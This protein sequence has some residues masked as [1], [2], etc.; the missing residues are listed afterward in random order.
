MGISSPDSVRAVLKE[1]G[2]CVIMPTYD[3]AGTLSDVISSVLEYCDDLIVINDGCTDGTPEILKKFGQ[4]IDVLTHPF[5]WGK[6]VALRNGLERAMERGFSH[7]IS[8]DS[9]GQHSASD[10]A[11]FAKALQEMPGTDRKSVV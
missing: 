4:K 9:D 6:G 5:N 2:C 3:N 10:I 8:I 7:A 11:G 1:R